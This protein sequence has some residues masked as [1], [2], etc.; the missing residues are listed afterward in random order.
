MQN[1]WLYNFPQWILYNY[2]LYGIMPSWL[3]H[4]LLNP[5]QVSV[6]GRQQ[7][8]FCLLA[9]EQLPV[10]W[11][12][13]LTLNWMEWNIILFSYGYLFQE[14]CLRNYIHK[15]KS[16]LRLLFCWVCVEMRLWKVSCT[17][18]IEN[19][20]IQYIELFLLNKNNYM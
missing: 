18:K 12:H 4:A 16:I 19:N 15:K 14:D 8:Q 2:L 6:K 3:H 17:M 20:I 13:P 11:I 5:S 10:V 9:C 7:Q 1:F